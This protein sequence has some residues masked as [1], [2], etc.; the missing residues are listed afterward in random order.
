MCQP[1]RGLGHQ[2][3]FQ[4]TGFKWM[5]KQESKSVR[6]WASREVAGFEEL[7]EEPRL[8]GAGHQRSESGLQQECQTARTLGH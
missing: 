5:I 1:Q 7:V 4:I 8:W 6:N 2:E 3:G